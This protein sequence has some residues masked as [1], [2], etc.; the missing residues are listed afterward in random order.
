MAR[1]CFEQIADIPFELFP[2]P[3]PC[4]FKRQNEAG[5]YTSLP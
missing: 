5:R 1:K 2:L 3:K 4:E